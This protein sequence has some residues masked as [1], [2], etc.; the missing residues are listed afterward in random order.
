MIDLGALADEVVLE[1]AMVRWV[2]WILPRDSED[3]N[4]VLNGASMPDIYM[5]DIPTHH[6]SF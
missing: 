5:F 4:F 1:N 2:R 3:C 6:P